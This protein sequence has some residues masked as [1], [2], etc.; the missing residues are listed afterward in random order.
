MGVIKEWICGGHGPFESDEPICPH[1]CTAVRQEFRTPPGIKSNR[2]KF[3]DAS[4][5][6]VAREF[7][8]SNLANHKGSV[9]RSVRPVENKAQA[10]WESF[11]GPAPT[12]KNGK[13]QGPDPVG[14]YLAQN[15]KD[16]EGAKGRGVKLDGALPPPRPAIDPKMRYN[17]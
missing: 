17:G 6:A 16:A 5:E 9:M 2:T 4:F 7:N 12:L 11:N 8:L 15:A 3:T 14:T 1:G 13:I 10:H